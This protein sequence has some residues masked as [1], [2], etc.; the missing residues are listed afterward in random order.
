MDG[1]KTTFLLGFGNFSG[2]MFNFG[3]VTFKVQK[4]EGWKNNYSDTFVCWISTRQQ[5]EQICVLLTLVVFHH[6]MKNTCFFY[7]SV[8]NPKHSNYLDLP[9]PSNIG[10]WRFS[11]GFPNAK[12]Y[13]WLDFWVG[14]RSNKQCVT[15]SILLLTT[16]IKRF[17]WY[18]KH[19]CHSL[20]SLYW[21]WSSHL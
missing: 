2:A 8:H 5:Q 14:G 10:K 6:R 12:M 21:G 13:W 3:R 15:V 18:L 7:S 17:H 11:S 19:V 4:Q 1:C 20:N 9:P 16:G